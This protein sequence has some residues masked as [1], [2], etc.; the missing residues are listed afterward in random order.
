MGAGASAMIWPYADIQYGFLDRELGFDNLHAL[1]AQGRHKAVRKLLRKGM[2]PN[3][4]RLEGAFGAE[5]DERGDSPMICTARLLSSFLLLVS[6][7]V[8]AHGCVE[9][10]CLEEFWL[11]D[12]LDDAE[13]PSNDKNANATMLHSTLQQYVDK[14]AER[15]ARLIEAANEAQRLE[16]QRVYREQLARDGAKCKARRRRQR[17]EAQQRRKL[18]PVQALNS[19]VT[20]RDDE[21]PRANQLDNQGEGMLLWEKKAMFP[22]PRSVVSA[23]RPRWVARQIHCTQQS[24]SHRTESEHDFMRQYTKLYDF[25]EQER[26]RRMRVRSI[27]TAPASPSRFDRQGLLPCDVRPETASF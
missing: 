16:D 4:R 2:D 12:E 1:A 18:P 9:F 25:L 26:S 17:L 21:P 8:I 7:G 27:V 3:A 6:E 11:A 23:D 15:R 22:R 20:G 19:T 10:G 13:I 24:Q 5:D 14:E